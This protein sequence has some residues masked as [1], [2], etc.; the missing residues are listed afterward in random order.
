MKH[1]KTLISTALALTLG[2]GAGW[3][4]AKPDSHIEHGGPANTKAQEDRKVLYWYDPM[5]PAQKF[6]RPGRSPFMD[7]DLVPKYADDAED[8][9]TVKIS[10]RVVQNLGIRT[11]TVESGTLSPQVSATGTIAYNERATVVIAPRSNAFVEKLYVRAPLDAVR[12]G[13]PLVQLLVPDWAGAQQEYLLLRQSQLEGAAELRRA[14]RERLILLG[15][16]EAQIK[17]IERSGVAQPRITLYAPSDGVVAELGVREGMTLAQGSQIFRLI[18]LATVWINAEIPERQSA[19]VKKNAAVDIRVPAYPGEIFKGRVSA[20]LPQVEVATRTLRARIEIAN[21]AF[22]LTPGMYATI[23]LAQKSPAQAQLTIP[24]EALIRTGTRTVVMLAE[25]E[26][27]YRQVEVVA[28]D[29][30]RG[31]TEI[32]QGLQAGD[33]VVVSG[34]FLIDSEASMRGEAVRAGEAPSTSALHHGSGRIESIDGDEVTLEHAPV[35]S[36]KMGAMTMPYKAPKSGLSALKIGQQV[37]FAFSIEQNGD[38]QLHTLKPASAQGAK[39]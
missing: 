1:T 30:A 38:F 7:M 11:A 27:R 33:S 22:R 29:E 5:V 39:P 25:G 26:G 6:D 13:Q 2:A 16:H 18:D 20:I 9:G 10:P 12:K 15:M 24:S 3:W 34:Q 8:A 37:Q 36:A 19:A 21:P 23:D 31:R 4:F 32:R 35:P 28:G 17:A 14:A